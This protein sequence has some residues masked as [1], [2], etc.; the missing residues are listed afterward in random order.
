MPRFARRVAGTL[1]F[2][3]V[4]L[5][6][7]AVLSIGGGVMGYASAAGAVRQAAPSLNTPLESLQEAPNKNGSVGQIVRLGPIVAGGR[8]V[9]VRDRLGKTVRM[10]VTAK[11]VIKK[12]GKR[13]APAALRANDYVI[14][15]G[16]RERTGLFQ[17]KGLVILGPNDPGDIT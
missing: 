10:V 4:P 1:G 15:V 2:W 12:N 7:A 8:M 3:F 14:G 11:T 9:V 13:V 5:V 16:N 17:A 6:L